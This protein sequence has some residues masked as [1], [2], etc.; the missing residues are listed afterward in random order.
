MMAI[1]KAG[2][3][4]TLDLIKWLAIA[5]MVIDHLR[6]LWPT[7]DGLFIVGRLAF[8]LFCLVIAANVV[9]SP[10]GELFSEANIRYLTWL[11]VFSTISELPYRWVSG[12]TTIASIMPTLMLGLIVA[13]GAYY[14]TREALLFAGLTLGLALILHRGLMYGCFGVLLP[15]AFVLALRARGA[16][17]W[18]PALL[19][20]AANSRNRWLA[21]QGVDSFGGMILIAA[22]TAPLL[23]LWLLAGSSRIRVWPVTRWGYWF[24]PG[25]LVALGVARALM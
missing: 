4:S 25:H 10:P 20:V 15:A 18:L 2:R 3:D 12:S 9:R 21:A 5:S 22:F 14:R 7:A 13:W 19:C 1:A 6:Y 17:W 16:W 11:V 23:G 24:Y 8:P